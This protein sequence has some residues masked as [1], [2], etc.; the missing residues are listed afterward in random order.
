[1]N[2]FEMINDA[3]PFLPG[4]EPVTPPTLDRAAS[5]LASMR[6]CWPEW[7]G[8]RISDDIHGYISV[9][10]CIVY[11]ESHQRHSF[12]Y[13]EIC[14]VIE[15]T[16]DHIRA[17]IAMGENSVIANKNGQVLCLKHHE[18]WPPVGLFTARTIRI[19]SH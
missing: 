16:P 9:G 7:Q 11:N 3:T 2:A 4:F 5:N 19:P 15:I 18:I 17:V 8:P 12:H 1:M 13:T 10:G 6:L 14:K